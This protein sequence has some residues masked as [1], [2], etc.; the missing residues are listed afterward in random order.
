MVV[1]F[2]PGTIPSVSNSTHRLLLLSETRPLISQPSALLSVPLWFNKPRYKPD[3]R[4]CKGS[5]RRQ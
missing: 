5:H 4:Y 1:T 3:I 2:I